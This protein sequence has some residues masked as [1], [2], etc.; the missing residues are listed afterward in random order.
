MD[1]QGW[2]KTGQSMTGKGTGYGRGQKNTEKTVKIEKKKVKHSEMTRKNT[3]T[4]SVQDM[5]WLTDRNK[6]GDQKI[7][8][9]KPKQFYQINKFISKIRV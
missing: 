7:V 3:K 4:D 1:K 5:D 6:K 8:G 9:K 2:D